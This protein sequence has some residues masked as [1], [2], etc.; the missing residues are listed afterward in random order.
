[1][2]VINLSKNVL[3][4][5]TSNTVAPQVGAGAGPWQ[6]YETT[7]TTTG[8]KD[9]ITIPDASGVSVTLSFSSSTASIEATDSPPD[10]L[11]AGSPVTVTWPA[12]VVGT[13]TSAQLVGF[14]AFRVNVATGTSVKLSARV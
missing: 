5:Q 1:M 13:T 8:A 9:W 12:G 2:A 7:Y 3:Q 14:T 10:T 6:W 11:A 4:P